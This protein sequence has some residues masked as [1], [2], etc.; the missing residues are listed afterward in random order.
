[1]TYAHIARVKSRAIGLAIE[2]DRLADQVWSGDDETYLRLR[3]DIAAGKVEIERDSLEVSR[4]VIPGG[5][6]ASWV[7]QLARWVRLLRWLL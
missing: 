5:R 6:S 7:L 1:M 4:G 3:A 2:C